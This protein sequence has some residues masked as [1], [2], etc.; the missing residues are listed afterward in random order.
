MRKNLRKAG[1]ILFILIIATASV[2]ADG[3]TQDAEANGIDFSSIYRL[4]L[5]LTGMLAGAIM[6]GKFVFDIISGTLK[7]DSEPMARRKA[8]VSFLIG[9]CLFMF[10]PGAVKYIF[11]N[12]VNQSTRVNTSVA[13]RSA[14]LAGLTGD[15][16]DS[17]AS[18]LLVD[19]DA[20]YLLED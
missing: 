8:V 19:A 15:S 6:V 5:T 11:A 3:I 16:V 14:F 12:G 2:F 4:L 10:T 9:V 7:S 17:E 18:V 1:M 20:A 13:D